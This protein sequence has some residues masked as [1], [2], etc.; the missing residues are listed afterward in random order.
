MTDLPPEIIERLKEFLNEDIRSGD[1]TTS[2]LGTHDG[3][4][5]GTF[6]AKSRSILAGLKDAMAI[7]EIMGLKFK[8]LAKEGEWVEKKKPVLRITGQASVILQVE[9]VSLNIIMRMSGV[10]TKTRNM[11]ALAHQGNNKV[12]V[13][14]TRKTTPGFR[15]FEKRAVQIGGGDPHRYALDDMILIKNNHISVIG[16]VE[17]AVK[18]ARKKVS[19]SKKVS[20]EVRDIKECIAAAKAGADIILLDNFTPKNVKEAD[21]RLKEEGLRDHIILEASGGINE[22]NV[23]EY[24]RSGVDVISSGALTHSYIASDFNMLLELGKK[25]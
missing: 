23:E 11:V 5:V 8:A 22:E 3:K 18:A 21:L 2:I 7:A 24:G 20:C 13:A 9:R 14:A 25:K 12:R 10:A 4:G 17:K 6:Y 19:F 15:F 1:I 16:S